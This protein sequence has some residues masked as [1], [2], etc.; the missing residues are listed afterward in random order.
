M[1]VPAERIVVDPLTG[2]LGYGLEYTY[3]VMERIRTSAFT[4][5]P[6]AGH[7]DD[8]QYRL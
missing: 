1:G 7:A 8:R 5:D 6:H 4:G 3:S 2:A